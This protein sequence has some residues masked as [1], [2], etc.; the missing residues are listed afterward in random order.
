MNIDNI[1][2]IIVELEGV[3]GA[4]LGVITTVIVTDILRRKGKL[5]IF[6]IKA[7]GIFYYNDN[8]D[9]SVIKRKNRK[10]NK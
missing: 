4:V 8:V 9:S 10:I 5:E 3:I 1:I 6:I 2:K 7:E